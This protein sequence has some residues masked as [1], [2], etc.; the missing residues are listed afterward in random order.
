M[1]SFV[2]IPAASKSIET[3]LVYDLLKETFDLIPLDLKNINPSWNRYFNEATL[4]ISNNHLYCMV[5]KNTFGYSSLLNR[6][7]YYMLLR[8]EQECTLTIVYSIIVFLEWICPKDPT[9]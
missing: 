8:W 7:S 9:T 4:G 2:D 1:F 6:H 5:W 3:I